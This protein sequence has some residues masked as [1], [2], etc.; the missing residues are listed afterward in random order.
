MA[1]NNTNRRYVV[2]NI[3]ELSTIDFNEVYETSADTI[4]KSVD[5]LRTF[6]KFD[7]ILADVADYSQSEDI[8]IPSQV[9]PIIREQL[10]SSI[11]ALTTR[12]QIFTHEEIKQILATSDWVNPN[13]EV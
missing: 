13:P 11:T 2:F 7:I 6:V 12:S 9:E 3:S 5:E 10:P 4:R 1:I 8:D